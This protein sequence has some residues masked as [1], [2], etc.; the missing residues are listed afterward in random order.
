MLNKIILFFKEGILWRLYNRIQAHMGMKFMTVLTL[1]IS[2]LMVLGT[3]FVARMMADSQYHALETRGREMGQLLGKA[4]TDA[5]IHRDIIALDGLIAETVK[6]ED[7]LYAYMLDES[8]TILNNSYVS[9]N[10]THPEVKELLAKETI[11][12]VAALTAKARAKLNPV[13]VQVDIKIGNT[14]IGA[15]RMGFSRAG[16]QRE[17]RTIIWMLLGTSVVIIAVL[18]LMIFVMVRTMIVTPSQEAVAV[19]SNIGAGDLSHR[20]RVRSMDELGAI[21]RGLNRMIIG[22]KGMIES[23]QVAARNTERV[24]R[25]VKGT[26]LQ[27]TE[28]S[29]IQTE[30]VEEA[31]S[32]VNEMHFSLKEIAGNVEDLYKTSEQTS[33]SVIEMSASI[34][35]VA[36][37]MSELS[38]SIEDTS[39]AITQMS[40]AI[41]QIAEHVEV[42]SASAE[43][44]AASATEISASV[45]EVESNARESAALAEAVASDA[46]QLGMRSIEKTIDGMT[47]IEST[48]L[49]TAEVV[50]R[51]GER[52][53]NVGTILTVIEDITDQTSLLAL[54][55]AILAAQAGEHGKGFAVVAAEIRELANRTAASTQE[56]G[57]LIASVQEESR[58]AVEVM[59]EEISMVEDGARLAR[60][61]GEALKKILERADQSRNMSRSISKAAAEQARGIRQVS[62]AVA[63]INEMTHQ[64]A[65][66][67][68]EQKTG[69]EQIMRTSEKMRELTHFAKAS[70]D[71]QAR[72]GK[73]ITSAVENITGRIRMVNRAAGEVQAGSDL[74]VKA[75]E[76]IKDIAKS[77]AELAAGLN[78]AMDVMVTQSE[79]LN[80][81]ISKFRT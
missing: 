6:S 64:I 52:A 8:N 58:E 81:E 45:K 55:A 37:T 11:D 20:V 24:W 2:V 4:G 39:T 80:K 76:R 31:S 19:A 66:A 47:R 49:R 62:D 29:K 43:D 65:R 27:I 18:A 44:T 34:D 79:T 75:I 40:A 13:E 5:L 54:N 77:N 68:N 26:S 74:V 9:F 38:S 73:G 12:D 70:T 57:T 22:L 33:S 67:A 14:R 28:G 71:E 60:D 69:S 41:R 46:Q 78:V 16:V 17:A 50:N 53:E 1:V 10:R 63:K 42:L 48:A 35:E 30:S 61:A 21:G 59:Q 15:V 72:G 25:E 51:L 36:R 7:M 3:F 23:V 56:I 32:S